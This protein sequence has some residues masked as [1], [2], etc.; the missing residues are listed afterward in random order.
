VIRFELLDTFGSELAGLRWEFDHFE[1]SFVVQVAFLLLIKIN[2][3]Y[4]SY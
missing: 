3:L 2:Y 1:V 4:N